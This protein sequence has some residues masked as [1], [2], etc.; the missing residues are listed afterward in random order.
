MREGSDIPPPRGRQPRLSRR[1]RVL[2]AAVIAAVIILLLSLRGIAGFYTD[3]LW[4][5]SLGYSAVWRG[6]LV[7]QVVLALV[8][9]A[10]M[11]V[12]LW[13]NLYIA[14][15]IAPSFRPPG[16]EEEFVK[17]YHDTIG[18]R[19][20]ILRISVAALFA[21]FWGAGAG[22]RW[23]DWILWRNR[24]DF[25]IKDP[26]FN[27]DVGFYVFELPF[28]RFFVNW[29]F[30]AFVVVLIITAAAHYLNGG[31]RMNA[32]V[33]RV[34]P[35]VK[36]HL[37]V[38][39]A[40]LAIVKAVDYWYQRYS[41]NFS[42]RGV[43]DGASYTDVNAQLPA[44][45]LLILISLAAALLLI[46]N[47]F[48]RG[49]VLPVVAVG[50][51]AF[52]AIVMGNI[53][54]AIY[55]RLVVEPNELARE[56]EFIQR[57]ID[58]TRFAYGFRVEDPVTG[59]LV[60]IPTPRFDFD[61]DDED[62]GELTPDFLQANEETIRNTRLLDPKIVSPTFSRREVE[63]DQFRFAPDL[64]V[65]RY[66]IDGQDR[67]VVVAARELNLGGVQ[68]GWENQHVASTHGYGLAIAPA[69]AISDEGEPDF[70]VGGLPTAIDSSIDVGLGPDD[71]LQPRI[72]VGEGL[73]GYA[74]VRAED[75]CEVDFPLQGGE[76]REGSPDVAIEDEPAVVGVECGARGSNQ[77]YYYT[78][79]DGVEA[80]G[81]IRRLAFALRFQDLNPIFS[82]LIGDESR[83]I[84][85]RDVQTRV[86]E[87][88]PFLEFDADSYP[89]II[90]GRIVFIVDAYTTTN[91]YPY[92]QNADRSS[93]PAG[94]DLRGGFNY[95]RNSVKAV[96]DAYNGTVDFYIVDETDPM[97][98]AYSKAF[99]DLFKTRDDPGFTDELI[100]H[101]RYPEDMFRIQTN[102]WATYQLTDPASFF[103][104]VA[105]WAVALDPGEDLEATQ[106]TTTGADGVA[107]RT[108]GDRIP[109]YYLQMRLPGE[110]EQEFVL[111]R[112]FVPRS[113]SEGAL[114]QELT[115]FMMGRI[116]DEGNQ[117]LV[118]YRLRGTAV[119]G[120]VL[121]N[122][123]MLND[124]AIAEQT[125]LLGQQG[126]S[127]RLGNMML[128]PLDTVEGEE[129]VI[130]VRPLYVDTQEG[131][132]GLPLLRR[133]I[134]AYD[135]TVRM[136]P[137]LEL[138]LGALFVDRED[139]DQNC[140]GV[141]SPLSGETIVIDDPP[142][143][144]DTPDP[145][146]D[147]DPTP[148]PT[149]TPEP[150][151]TPIP[152]E[153][154]PGDAQALL[155][156]AQ[157]AFDAADEALA[158]GDLGRYQELIDEAQAALDQALE[159]IAEAG[160]TEPEPTQVPTPTPT[161]EGA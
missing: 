120:P 134:V 131:Q 40:V 87:L 79:E 101:L 30:T 141:V 133:V 147:D 56:S 146:E 107:V 68:P 100:S 136:C 71:A 117:S 20:G 130:Y 128:L 22:S 31:I 62:L 61:P 47:I 70:L 14:D 155:E 138:A 66:S 45:K 104:D 69:N 125:T 89:A 93:L 25:G 43:V 82:G 151:T 39:L 140:N 115:A 72:Y 41:L 32:P 76:Q 78:G 149:P 42:R 53:Y 85:N 157:A 36:A 114:R 13:I 58:A 123:A 38:L 18:A 127:V 91:N 16:P 81:I 94:S 122:A 44:I 28:I 73:S 8:F 119:D 84:Y 48:R 108:T 153:P 135:D 158:S 110:T 116:D 1:G 27:V 154:P 55:Q 67:L 126:S 54:P 57:N 80:G 37:S 9:I 143:D 2:I 113:I 15:R 35:Q 109:P 160:G 6:V 95:V 121:A 19:S 139:L 34:T 5:D 144:T 7:A 26:Q 86:R 60:D 23:Q 106:S 124:T 92:S 112:P 50:L 88:A 145:A 118:S 129:R 150:S 142:D 51:W 21:L 12:L 97:I 74:I 103:D 96:V 99:P 83:F 3:F 148:T 46:V 75:R 111:M 17:R 98:Q 24:V 159:L 90:D 11:F 132:G 105:A 77:E 59:E 4:F 152:V 161:P 33:Q 10:F 137:T 156:Q 52:V 49:W 102:M 63:R 65:D 64:D 29:V